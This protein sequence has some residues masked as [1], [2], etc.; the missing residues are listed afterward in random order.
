MNASLG[1]PEP[2]V[3]VEALQPEQAERD[4]AASTPAASRVILG[5]NF[6]V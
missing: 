1:C 2:E 3:P 6:I 4:D 5:V